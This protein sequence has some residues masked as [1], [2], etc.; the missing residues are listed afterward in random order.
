MPQEKD[1]YSGAWADGHDVGDPWLEVKKQQFKKAPL[2]PES[3][4][5]WVDATALKRATPE[6]PAL[7]PSIFLPSDEKE[8]E[9]GETPPLIEASLKDHPEIQGAYDCFRPSWEK[10]ATEYLRREEI[11]RVYAELFNLHTQVRKQGEIVEVVLGLGLLEWSAKVNGKAVLIRRHAIVGR[12]EL[13]FEPAKGVIRVR[14]PGEGAQLQIEDDMLEAE[15]RPDPSDYAR[16]EMQ[17][18]EIGDE[19]W[20]KSQMHSALRTWTGSLSADSQWSEGLGAQGSSGHSPTMSFA[21]ALILRK[22]SQAGMVRVYDELIN[23]LSGDS[24]EVPEGWGALIDDVGD[25]ADAIDQGVEEPGISCNSTAL[26]TEI[27]FPLL[28][29]REQGQIVEA[30]EHQ[31]GVLVRGPPGTG[32]SHTI[33]NL[34]CHLLATGKRVL[35]TAETGRALQVLKNKLPQEIQPLCVSLLGQGGD[36]MAELNTAVQGITTKQSSY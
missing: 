36:A 35:I 25:H 12:V 17:L 22:R 9:E 18:D 24:I 5:L 21:P 4:F 27:F 31:R 19:I 23:Q 34:I 32:K 16:V 28:A 29:N 33:A 26:P 11:Q 7:L 20:D 15:F 8:T 6:I 1:C 3:L 13:E 2:P 30:I 14:P 10:W